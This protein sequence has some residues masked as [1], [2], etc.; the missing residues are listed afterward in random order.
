MNWMK[1]VPLDQWV[2]QHH[3]RSVSASLAVI[4]RMA[5]AV[6]Y[7]HSGADTGIAVVH[8]DIK[9]ANV[10]IA[11]EDVKLVDFG[12]AR[13]MDQSSMTFAGTPEYIAPEVVLSGAPFSPATDR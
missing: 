6:D 8:R 10:L 9:P 3:G 7:L 13:M 5:D 2:R 1:G 11:G 4:R 12:F